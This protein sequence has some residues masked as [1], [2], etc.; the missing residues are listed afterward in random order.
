MRPEKG[1]LVIGLA[2]A[3][4]ACGGGGGAETAGTTATTTGATTPAT[5]TTGA[6][7]PATTTGDT[8][9]GGQQ[10]GDACAL[11][12]DEQV[13]ELL[14]SDD[15]TTEPGD[16]GSDPT[17]N[18]TSEDP[19]ASMTIASYEPGTIDTL[20]TVYDEDE[21]EEVAGLGER[22]V[23]FPLIGLY[24]E[25]AGRTYQIVAFGPDDTEVAEVLLGNLG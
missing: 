8:T 6:T 12:T 18:W 15:F 23:R 16:P 1:L 21:V 25:A 24:V 5:T 11:L 2:L 4:A 9:T 17:C 14:G 20:L 7:T 3:L 22:A 10:A 13:A 19:I